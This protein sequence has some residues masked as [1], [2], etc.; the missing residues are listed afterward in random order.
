MVRFGFATG[1]VRRRWVN[2]LRASF[3]YE[4]A[5]IDWQTDDYFASN[6]NGEAVALTCLTDAMHNVSGQT[7]RKERQT[8]TN[9]VAPYDVDLPAHFRRAAAYLA[10]IL[11]RQV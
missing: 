3:A 6:S 2:S 5:S 7:S 1:S 8:I 11:R 4:A 9:P 10:R